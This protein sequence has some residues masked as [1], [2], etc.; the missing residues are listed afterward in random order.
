M[1]RKIWPDKGEG[2][3]EVEN[4][5]SLELFGIYGLLVISRTFG[6]LSFDVYCDLPAAFERCVHD[7]GRGFQNEKVT[8]DGRENGPLMALEI[9]AN[10]TKFDLDDGTQKLPFVLEEGD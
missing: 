4:H 10:N 7:I 8:E 5:T 9:V 2:M 1:D 3:D 6:A